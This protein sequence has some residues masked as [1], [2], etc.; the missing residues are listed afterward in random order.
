VALYQVSYIYL[1]ADSFYKLLKHTVVYLFRNRRFGSGG[2][3][4]PE[5]RLSTTHHSK[6]YT[7]RGVRIFYFDG[8]RPSSIGEL[9]YS[10][11]AELQEYI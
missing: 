4:V 9:L 3:D 11:G 2:A 10:D 6:S 1:L 8:L 7:S 5:N